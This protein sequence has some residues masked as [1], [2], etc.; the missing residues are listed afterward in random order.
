MLKR[1]PRRS[2]P[3]FLSQYGCVLTHDRTRWCFGLCKPHQGIGQCGR[4]YPHTLKS[5]RQR[6]IAQWQRER[7]RAEGVG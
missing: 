5:L 3:R 2:N 7:S 6:A 1:K 4:L